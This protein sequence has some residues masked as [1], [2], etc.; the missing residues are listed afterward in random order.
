MVSQTQT[1]MPRKPKNSNV[2]IIFNLI[3]KF[4][5]LGS[6][7]YSYFDVNITTYL[8][9]FSLKAA[10]ISNKNHISK[11]QAEEYSFILHTRSEEKGRNKQTLRELNKC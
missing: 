5:I 10:C 1:E 2:H 7:F 8:L 9:Y 11:D 4:T 6:C 3:E